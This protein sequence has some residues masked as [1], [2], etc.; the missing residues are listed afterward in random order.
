MKRLARLT[1][2]EMTVLAHL[3]SGDDDA[4]IASTLSLPQSDVTRC[5]RAIFEK[6]E[7]PD[8][9]EAGRVA[10][11]VLYLRP[12]LVC[13][14]VRRELERAMSVHVW[15]NR[16]LESAR[17]L[18]AEAVHQ[19]RRH[20]RIAAVFS[21]NRIDPTAQS[22]GVRCA[23]CEAEAHEGTQRWRAFHSLE[24]DDTVV[25]VVFCPECAQR[26]FGEPLG[27]PGN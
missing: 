12:A 22:E 23:E 16:E 24:A 15:A 7:L 13:S 2:D 1:H 21:P 27:T 6:L 3:A 5:V 20:E 10:A 4:A 18:R 11:A 19:R 14:S 25:T 9:D 26:E 17:A 8:S